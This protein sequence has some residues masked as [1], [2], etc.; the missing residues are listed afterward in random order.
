VVEALLGGGLIRQWVDPAD[1]RITSA[2]SRAVRAPV[3][4]SRWHDAWQS[5]PE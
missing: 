2:W 1:D 4:L 3:F 5:A